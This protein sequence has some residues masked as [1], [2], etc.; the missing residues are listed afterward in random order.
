MEP[1]H[2]PR[3]DRSTVFGRSVFLWAIGALALGHVAGAPPTAV[4]AVGAVGAVGSS[5]P[6]V[7]L[8]STAEGIEIAS[9]DGART[10]ITLDAGARFDRAQALDDGWIAAGVRSGK[11]LLLLRARRAAGE[12]PERMVVPAA[13]GAL[14]ATPAPIVVDGRLVGMTW[15]A[16]DAPRQLAVRYAAWLGDGWG[17][18]ETV[19]APGPGSQLAA[20]G[21][22]L[23]DGSILVVWSAFDGEDD[24][25]LWSLRS[26]GSWSAAARVA[27]DNAVPDITPALALDDGRPLAVWSRFDGKGYS[28]VLSRFASGSWSEPTPVAPT[29]SLFPRLRTSAE[30]LL[31]VYRDVPASGW[32]VVRLDRQ[33]RPAARATIETSGEEEP[34]LVGVDRETV[35]LIP[36]PGRQEV[37]LRWSR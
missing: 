29:G 26:G 1:R 21:A 37:T 11:A 22:A 16:G 33:L 14:V 2:R 34:V 7:A 10:E 13:G 5:G 23:P 3:S 9:S 19:A 36:G 4:A 30:G 6:S 15:L 32:S 17:P 27:A 20:A 18:S 25:I 24:E 8:L 35:R 28:L 31:V 12:E